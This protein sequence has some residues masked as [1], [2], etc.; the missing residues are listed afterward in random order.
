MI[1][2]LEFSRTQLTKKLERLPPLLRVVF[3]AACA[4]R[5]LPTYI[6]FSDLREQGDPEAITRALARLWEDVDGSRM[7]ESEVQASI[8]THGCP[9]SANAAALRAVGRVHTISDPM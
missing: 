3:A 7:K 2:V 1:P 4:E 9:V 5:L 6:T 8:S